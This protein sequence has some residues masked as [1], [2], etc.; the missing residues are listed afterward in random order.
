MGSFCTPSPQTKTYTPSPLVTSAY[1]D[2]SS[3]AQALSGQPLPGYYDPGLLSPTQRAGI[4][5]TNAAFGSALP[6]LN[7][8]AAYGTAGAAP[9]SQLSGQDIYRYMNPYLG[10]VA[11]T[12]SA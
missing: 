5:N 1:G 4:A 7:T 10:A 6:W 8:A 3:R 9:V 12:T 2:I 11:D